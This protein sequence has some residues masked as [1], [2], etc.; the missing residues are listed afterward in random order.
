MVGGGGGGGLELLSDGN[1]YCLW[2][3]Y[4]KLT[5]HNNLWRSMNHEVKYKRKL[6]MNKGWVSSVGIGT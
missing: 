2:E 1:L 4:R 5:V 6:N 3:F